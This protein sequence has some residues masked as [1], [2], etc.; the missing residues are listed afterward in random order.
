MIVYGVKYD[1]TDNAD[2]EKAAEPPST[3]SINK[4]K[5]DCKKQLGP[6][7][8]SGKETPHYY[9]SNPLYRCKSVFIANKWI[10]VKKRLTIKLL[11]EF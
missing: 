1:C 9:I 2:F 6:W 5:A 3:W 4:E 8:T 10:D 7:S 11:T